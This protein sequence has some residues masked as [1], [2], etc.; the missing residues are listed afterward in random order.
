VQEDWR[1]PND[2]L[3]ELRGSLAGAPAVG[4]GLLKKGPLSRSCSP[5]PGCQL[6]ARSALFGVC[7]H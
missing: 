6:S 5:E 2:E 4:E 1:G 7:S 3:L